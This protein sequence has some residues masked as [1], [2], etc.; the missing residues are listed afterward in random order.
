MDGLSSHQS[1]IAPT[2]S[3]NTDPESR[4]VWDLW[5]ATGSGVSPVRLLSVHTQISRTLENK[6]FAHSC[7][8]MG[9]NVPGPTAG[10]CWTDE[11][12][13]GLVCALRRLAVAVR[14]GTMWLPDQQ[15][16]KQCIRTDRRAAGGIDVHRYR[17]THTRRERKKQGGVVWHQI[18][19]LRLCSC[20]AISSLPRDLIYRQ[21]LPECCAGISCIIH[22]LTPLGGSCG[23]FLKCCFLLYFFKCKSLIPLLWNTSFLKKKLQLNSICVAF[24]R[25]PTTRSH[26]L[27]LIC[28]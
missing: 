7:V 4:T 6:L 15:M 2:S 11:R 12:L 10:W 16:C 22:H 21:T 5:R 20:Y 8:R 14:S 13:V 3:Q 24:Y 9:W 19:R 25:P 28:L 17:H 23:W 18:K 1:C 26:S 27:A